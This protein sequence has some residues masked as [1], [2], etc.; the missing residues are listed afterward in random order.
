[1]FYH[2]LDS[3]T[4]VCRYAPPQWLTPPINGPNV[5]GNPHHPSKRGITI[6]YHSRPLSQFILN[7]P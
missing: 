4:F 5:I 3:I 2:I 1:M 6:L 7:R